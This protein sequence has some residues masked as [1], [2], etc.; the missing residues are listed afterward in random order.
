MGRFLLTRLLQFPLILAIIYLTTFFLVWVAPGDPFT[1]TDKKVDK[2]VIEATKERLHAKTW[3]Q[4]LGYYPWMMLKGDLGPSLTYEE[5][6]VTKIVG[7]ALPVSVR[8]GVF[9]M[10]IA[11]IV[12]VG[13]GAL[14]AVRRG[15]AFDWF[16]LSVALIG[17]SLPSFVS[18]S[19]LFAIFC[20]QFKLFPIGTWGSPRDLILPGL[21]LSL[22]PMAYIARLT[23][24]AM[25]DVLSSD[26]IRTARAKGL[27][28]SL[29]IW[30]HALKNA[31]LPVL[32]YLGPAAAATLTGS[33]VVEK[34]FNIPGLGQHFVNSVLNRD[35]TLVLG[36]VMIYSVFLLALN[37]LVDV[38]YAFIDPR[39]D[40]TVKT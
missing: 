6:S 2:A 9:A 7:D 35:Q 16:S 14:A 33:F 39:I 20:S 21:A 28:R 17:I 10:I 4:F 40:V 37:L 19:V 27:S 22:A 18:A 31:F 15:G 36:T 11:V 29:I 24:V 25:I 34:V 12:G 38:A 13:I 8:L 3:Y 26:F 23:R 32:S 30:K 5:W 1:R